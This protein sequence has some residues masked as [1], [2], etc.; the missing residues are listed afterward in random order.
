MQY[1]H[2][3]RPIKLPHGLG[4]YADLT[5]LYHLQ[6]GV[7]DSRGCSTFSPHPHPVACVK[8]PLSG[9]HHIEHD[10]VLTYLDIKRTNL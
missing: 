6:G 3:C 7:E 5:N 8:A 1:I 2:T 4:E 9:I 10:F